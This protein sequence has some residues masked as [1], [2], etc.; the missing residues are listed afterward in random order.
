M[1]KITPAARDYACEPEPEV[2]IVADHGDYEV[3]RIR[4]GDEMLT[5]T[6]ELVKPTEPGPW[7]RYLDPLPNGCFDVGW[8]R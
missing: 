8:R 6:F 7:E 5:S 4:C 2:E 3:L 1:T